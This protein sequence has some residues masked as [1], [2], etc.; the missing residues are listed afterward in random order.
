MKFVVA[1]LLVITVGIA[2]TLFAL[3]NSV[4]DMI[5]RKSENLLLVSTQWIINRAEAW[6]NK[7]CRY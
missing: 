1:F 3:Y 6:F 4:S 5:V 7:T 2:A